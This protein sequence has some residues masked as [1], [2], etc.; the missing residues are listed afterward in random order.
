MPGMWLWKYENTVYSRQRI[1][2]V[3]FVS[4]TFC[5]TCALAPLY[6]WSGT[7][8]RL[9]LDSTKYEGSNVCVKSAMGILHPG[10]ESTGGRCVSWV[11]TQKNKH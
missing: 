6:L 7:D 3:L 11:D 2:I 1:K 5:W 4:G 8:R 10:G 9:W